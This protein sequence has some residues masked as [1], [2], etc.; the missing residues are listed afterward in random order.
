MA[1]DWTG[2]GPRVLLRLDRDGGRPL[3][4]QLQEQLRDLIRHGRLSAGEKVPSSRLLAAELG[5]SRGVVTEVYA[6][7]QAEGYLVARD[8]SATRVGAAAA[9]PPAAPTAPSAARS[10]LRYDFRP[11]I[12]DLSSFPREAWE[13]A[14]RQAC[15]ELPTGLLSYS[16]PYGDATLRA[17]LAAYL[18]RVRGAAV[19]PAQVVVCAGYAQGSLLVLR[20][21]ADQGLRE[22]AVEDPGDPDLRA[23]AV[24]VGLRVLPIPVDAHGLDVDVLAG[25]AAR[26][27]V[28]TPAH[29]A[30]LGVAL[31][32]D[33]RAALLAW[34]RERDATVLE[35]DYDAELRYDCDPVGV[36]QG[37]APDRVALLGS[38]S[39]TVSPALRLGWAVAPPALAPAV[40]EHKLL[41]DRGSPVLDQL[42][43]A[44]FLRSGAFDRHLRHMRQ[45]YAARRTALL[46]ALRRHAPHVELTGLAAGFQAVADLPPGSDEQHVVA[47]ARQRSIG[48]YGLAEYRVRDRGAPP[49]LLLGF[50]N[51]TETAIEEGI[52]GIA[53]LL[54]TPG[55]R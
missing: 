1:I 16:D 54:G 46:A 3:G 20:A 38:V 34:A 53:D 4:A 21:L 12:P 28:L 37:L 47:Q 24:H 13:R 49:A 2:P 32:P 33:R 44:E 11:R 31:S 8:G 43:L 29:Q 7:L 14:V 27:V 18:R 40:G 48:L 10:V 52:A 36:L 50:G 9:A 6:Q 25:T 35:D 15:R 30:P 19:D 51:L 41:A 39:K 45:R 22:L 17:T 23:T 26:A 55:A 5:V 42:A